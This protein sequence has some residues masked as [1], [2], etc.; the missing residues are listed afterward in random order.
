MGR[1]NP[2]SRRGCIFHT[3]DVI[4]DNTRMRIYMMNDYEHCVRWYT[5]NYY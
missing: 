4:L 2:W 1:L 5:W 3:K